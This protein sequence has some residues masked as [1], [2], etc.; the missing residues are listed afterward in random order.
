MTITNPAARPGAPRQAEIDAALLL[1]KRMGLSPADLTAIP[2][3]PP[4]LP[5]FADYVPVVSAA[6]T[7]GTRR[8]YG[9]YWNRI[10]E[11]WGDRHL[12]EPS[13]SEVRQLMAYVKTHVVARR[14]AR[15]GRSAQEHLVGALRCLYRHAEDDGLI[16]EGD[17]PGPQGSQTPA[18]N[19]FVASA[20][21]TVRSTSRRFRSVSISRARNPAKVPGK[22]W[23]I[24]VHAVRH[25]L[26]APV[27]R[28]PFWV[29]WSAGAGVPVSRS[30]GPGPAGPVP[31]AAGAAS[32]TPSDKSRSPAPAARLSAETT[33]FCA[34]NIQ[35]AVNHTVS[36]VRRRS[37]KVPAVTDV[38]PPQAVHLYRPSATAHPPA[39]PQRGQA[40][41]CGHRSQ[42]G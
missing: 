21:A 41:P 23:L 14:S 22:R 42:S 6:V 28:L 19:P 33:P 30:A 38:R 25:Q 15:G 37:N 18:P 36:G 16:P 27:W 13:P 26:P 40:K 10:V 1:L 32:A 12:D 3:A 2:K 4:E 20:S 34:A 35:Q 9:S 5:T 24:R 8:A 31:G 39:C 11:H 17:N 7:A 29:P